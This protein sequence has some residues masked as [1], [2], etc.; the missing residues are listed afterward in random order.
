MSSVIGDPPLTSEP[1]TCTDLAPSEATFVAARMSA[2][3]LSATPLPAESEEELPPHPAST[4]SASAS[5]AQLA[6]PRVSS[7]R[8]IDAPLYIETRSAEGELLRP[9]A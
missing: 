9:G 8:R 1:E 3:A 4:A 7:R 5:A 6:G 2:G